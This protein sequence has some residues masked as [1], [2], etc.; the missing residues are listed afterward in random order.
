MLAVEQIS[1]SYGAR[2]VLRD[3]SLNCQ[4]GQI[5]GLVGPSGCG[6]TTLWRLVAALLHAESGTISIDEEPPEVCVRRRWIGVVP[7]GATGLLPQLNLFQ[8]TAIP[9]AV[10]M[11][12][13]TTRGLPFLSRLS[14]VRT[15]HRARIA[16]AARLRP[17]ECSGG[18]VARALLARA[19]VLGPRLLVLDEAFSQLDELTAEELYKDLQAVVKASSMM[20][21][22]V[23]HSLTEVC[24]LCDV[25]VPLVPAGEPGVSTSGEPIAI[26]LPRPRVVQSLTDPRFGEL[27]AQLRAQLQGGG[28]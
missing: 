23:S 15:M 10:D 2:R 28:K 27:R 1:F 9:L 21:I 12:K 20:C 24:T 19:L 6:K 16:S 11:G 5:L 14:V 18:M 22:I 3:V 13:T 17:H 4:A 8:N 26:D 7:Q 25:V